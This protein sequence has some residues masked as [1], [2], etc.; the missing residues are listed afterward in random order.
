MSCVEGSWCRAPSW[1]LATPKLLFPAFRRETVPCSMTQC[2]SLLSSACVVDN[3]CAVLP[4][5]ANLC[6]AQDQGA[7]RTARFLDVTC[8]RRR[9]DCPFPRE[10]VGV[11][12]A[13]VIRRPSGSLAAAV[14]GWCPQGP[15]DRTRGREPT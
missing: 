13:G 15:V 8:Q 14:G 12:A 11:L 3:A 7:G 10:G 2:S 4:I 9:S 6:P 1:D 5:D